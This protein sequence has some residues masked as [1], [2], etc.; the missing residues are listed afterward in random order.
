MAIPH[1]IQEQ[2]P[3]DSLLLLPIP[4]KLPP[5]PLP[6]LPSLISAF[7][8]YIDAS[9]AS[10][11]SPEDESIALPVLTS[12]MRQITRN[13]Q[14]LLNAARLGAAEAREELDGV[15]VKLREVEYERNRVREETQRCMDYESAHEPIDLPNVETFIASVDQTPK[16]D[17]GYEYAL[18]I[19]QLEHELEEIL[20][21][22]AQVAQ[23]TKDRDAYIRAKKEIKIKTD[24][25]DVHLAGF[26]RTANA[27]YSKSKYYPASIVYPV[28]VTPSRK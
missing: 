19:L 17:E 27:H 22:E 16:D 28:L 11:S 21:R 6:A 13:A 5:S 20:K 24:A 1:T 23:L 14:V 15:D 10:S 3:A 25:V 12:S 7:D 4:E 26:A 2:H 9:K 18:T 8:P